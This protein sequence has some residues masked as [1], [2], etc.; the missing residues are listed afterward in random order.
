MVKLLGQQQRRAG[1]FLSAAQ[2]LLDTLTTHAK[3]AAN[4]G[5]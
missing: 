1:R 5:Q 3:I 2:P 4:L